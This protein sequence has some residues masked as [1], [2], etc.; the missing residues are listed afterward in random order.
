MILFFLASPVPSGKLLYHPCSILFLEINRPQCIPLRQKEKKKPSAIS[1]SSSHSFLLQPNSN[2]MKSV[3]IVFIFS[4]SIYTSVLNH[5]DFYLPIRWI[6]FGKWVDWSII[7][8]GDTP[9][10]RIM[11]FIDL[12][13][14]GNIYISIYPGPWLPEVIQIHLGRQNEQSVEQKHRVLYSS[15]CLFS[16]H[17]ISGIPRNGIMLSVSIQCGSWG[18]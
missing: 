8:N 7:Y 10:I 13:N 3:L 18:F 2:Q 6:Y 9:V 15:A 16:P 17:K 1:P 12:Y 11:V 14:I 5:S 4:G